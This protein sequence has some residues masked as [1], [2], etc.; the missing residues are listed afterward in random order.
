MCLAGFPGQSCRR[1]YRLAISV[2]HPPVSIGVPI[3]IRRGRTRHHSDSTPGWRWHRGPLRRIRRRLWI[4]CPLRGILWAGRRRI[5]TKC[6][7]TVS[8]LNYFAVSASKRPTKLRSKLACTRSVH[9]IDFDP[10]SLQL[11][12]S[13]GMSH[14]NI[15][16]SGNQRDGDQL[17]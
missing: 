5:C 10:E 7:G 6:P 11:T 14:L 8:D 12:W 17:C 4:L 15:C 3:W 1:V 9:A 2:G 13:R 16:R